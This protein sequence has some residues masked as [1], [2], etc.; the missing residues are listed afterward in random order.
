MIME[1]IP[2]TNI[3]SGFQT[4]DNFDIN[5]DDTPKILDI[6]DIVPKARV[7]KFV[8]YSSPVIKYTKANAELP[9]QDANK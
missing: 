1:G 4:Q 7:R 5:A 3:G 8:G 6:V 9:K 2:K